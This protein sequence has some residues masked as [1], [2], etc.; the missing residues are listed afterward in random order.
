MDLAEA[1]AE[2]KKELKENGSGDV[3]VDWSKVSESA[4]IA[5]NKTDDET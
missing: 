2:A 5:V 4:A 3:S 1:L